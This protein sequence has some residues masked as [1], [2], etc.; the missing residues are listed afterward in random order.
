[1]TNTF[2]LF[3]S[4]VKSHLDND[5]WIPI[6]K[7]IPA[8]CNTQRQ[9][10]YVRNSIFLHF[11]MVN[12]VVLTPQNMVGCAMDAQWMCSGCT[13]GAQR[14]DCC[15]WSK[16]RQVCQWRRPKIARRFCWRP[17][18]STCKNFCVKLG[19]NQGNRPNFA[20]VAFLVGTNNIL[21]IRSQWRKLPY[22]KNV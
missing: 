5:I 15:G 2:F 13:A 1:M 9:T 14:Y 4:Y 6:Y 17:T 21:R 8:I 20:P 16:K 18:T 22:F 12:R 3:Y 7:T 19:Q 11:I 10:Q